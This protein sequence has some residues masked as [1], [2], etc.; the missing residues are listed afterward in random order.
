[1]KKQ[2]TISLQERFDFLVKLSTYLR[3][4]DMHKENELLKDIALNSPDMGASLGYEDGGATIRYQ[5]KAGFLGPG[6]RDGK[7]GFEEY[8]RAF[9]IKKGREYN[10]KPHV[11]ST[12]LDEHG[13]SSLGH[14]SFICRIFEMMNEGSDYVVELRRTGLRRMLTYFK[15]ALDTPKELDKIDKELSDSGYTN[16]DHYLRFLK[17]L[18]DKNR[19]NFG[20]IGNAVR[21]TSDICPIHA[22]LDVVK[23]RRLEIGYYLV[24]LQEYTK[25]TIKAGE[26]WHDLEPD[27][28]V[29]VYLPVL[30]DLTYLFYDYLSEETEISIRPLKSNQKKRILKLPKWDPEC[31]EFIEQK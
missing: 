19:T 9:C 3:E 4:K 10:L 23:G 24:F 26:R 25:A 6:G 31:R 18:E 5:A 17:E 30:G 8:Y 16:L 21:Q 12:L 28:D 27:T 22:E 7:F 11:V 29:P 1:M 20:H 2:K 14:L 13:D 15:K